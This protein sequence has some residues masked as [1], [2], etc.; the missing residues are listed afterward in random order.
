MKYIQVILFFLIFNYGFSQNKQIV[1]DAVFWYK[2]AKELEHKIE[3]TDFEKSKNDFSFRFRNNGQVVEIVKDSTN[4]SGSVTN[5]IYYR[6]KE[7]SERKTLFKKEFLS[8]AQAQN[9][10]DIVQIADILNLPSDEEIKNWGRGRDGKTYNVEYS[11]TIKYSIKSY[12]EP[13]SQEDIAVAVKISD[14][15]D[16]ISDTIA[17]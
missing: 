17:S 15:I 1:G 3:L 7:K 8:E 16:I 2:Y 10:Y 5:Y 14:F 12:W 11:D 6:R 4:I 9:I 13:S